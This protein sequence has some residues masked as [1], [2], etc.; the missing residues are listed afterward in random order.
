MAK[1]VA[2]LLALVV[3]AGG[4]Y[5]YWQVR[6]QQ[7]LHQAERERAAHL[8]LELALL[9][10]RFQALEAVRDELE[11]SN[12]KMRAQLAASQGPAAVLRARLTEL[13]AARDASRRAADE[14]EKRLAEKEGQLA[15]LQRTAD[16]FK[17]QLA[18]KDRRYAALQARASDLAATLDELQRASSALKQQVDIREKQLA[19]LRATQQELVEG[20]K[21]EIAAR[22]IQV[23]RVRDQLRVELVEEVLFDSGEAEI[24]PAGLGV[25]KRVGQIL[26][27]AK[28]R[29][30]DVEGHTD[31][32]PIGAELAKRFPT[33]W[34]LS[35]ARATNVARFLQDT[36]KIDPA[37]LSATGH[38]EYRPRQPNTTAE[39]RRKNRRIE[40]LLGPVLEPVRPA[41]R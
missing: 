19:E 1:W 24:K 30:I 10:P 3:I 41:A 15:G 14:L 13:E 20:M 34:E 23:E 40:I 25:L 5:Y 39:G 38:S 6:P 18:E 33:N 22:Q 11:S 2:T 36:V 17:S 35:T 7:A 4:A 8:D 16:D 27:K 29:N 12:A 28:H 32:I 37:L 21:Q 9:R 31:N 26:K